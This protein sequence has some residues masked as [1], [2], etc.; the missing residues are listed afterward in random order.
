MSKSMISWNAMSVSVVLLVAAAAAHSKAA[1]VFSKPPAWQSPRPEEVQAQAIRWLAEKQVDA[2]TRNKAAALWADLAKQPTETQVLLRLAA[3]F[4]LADQR[5]AKLVELCAKPKNQ[6]VLPSQAWLSDPQTPAFLG[7]NLRLL[8]GRWLVHCEMFD[9]AHEQ[10]SGLN[11]G[12]VVAPATLLFYRSVACYSLLHKEAGLKAI[13]ELLDGAEQSPRRYVTMARLMQEDLKILEDD[14]LD[15]VARRM[16]DVRRRLDL[17]R[18]GQKVRSVED[19]IIESLD[20]MIKKVEEQQVASSSTG[21]VQDTIRSRSPAPDSVPIGGKG[22]GEVTKRNV[23]S[24]DDWGHL[25][26]KDREEA[27]QRIGRDFPS[28]YRDVI[29]QYFRRLAAEGTE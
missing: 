3:T 25:P 17:G 21:G 15:H 5:S 22:P 13:A 19:G 2:A 29:E 8:Y 6:F 24:G 12:D 23:G 10:L 11:P 9:E 28:H 14:S 1:D 26:P 18:A 16:N 7:A 4:A 27:L 20:K